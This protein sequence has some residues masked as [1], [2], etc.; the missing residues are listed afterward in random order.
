MV[1]WGHRSFRRDRK[2]PVWQFVI[3]PPVPVYCR[4]T[5][6]EQAPFFSNPVSSPISTPS[7]SPSAAVT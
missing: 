6:A 7:G 5:P 3:L 4:W 2:T 1:R